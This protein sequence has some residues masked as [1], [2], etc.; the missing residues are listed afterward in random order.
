MFS[1]DINSR[2]PV[3]LG[4]RNILKMACSNDITTLTVPVLLMHEMTEVVHNTDSVERGSCVSGINAHMFCTHFLFR[5]CEIV[6]NQIG[7]NFILLSYC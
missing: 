4:L 1:D 7:V 2:H 6:Q 5:T 3:I